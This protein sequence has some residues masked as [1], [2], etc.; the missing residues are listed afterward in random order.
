[1]YASCN[2][3]EM[4]GYLEARIEAMKRRISQ[5][6]VHEEPIPVVAAASP[7]TVFCSVAQAS[8]SI[9]IS[10]IY[11]GGTVKNERS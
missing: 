7:L 3:Q 11:G 9:V 4:F 6:C 8:S 5:L 10:Q 1:M 2:A